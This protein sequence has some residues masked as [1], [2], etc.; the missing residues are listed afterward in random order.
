MKPGNQFF[1]KLILVMIR[2]A[3]F[4]PDKQSQ[5]KWRDKKGK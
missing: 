1:I 5:N 2:F 4:F 3:T